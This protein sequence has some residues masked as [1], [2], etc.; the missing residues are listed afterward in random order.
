MTALLVVLKLLLHNACF[1][2]T[3]ASS[4]VDPLLVETSTSKR[5]ETMDT[6]SVQADGD[7]LTLP[8]SLRV[9]ARKTPTPEQQKRIDAVAAKAKKKAT[10]AEPAPVKKKAKA[11]AKRRADGLVEGSAGA[12]LVDAVVKSKSGLTNEELCEMIGWKQCLPFLKKSC[13]QAGVKLTVTKEPG[14]LARYHGTKKKAKA[15]S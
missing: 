5:R 9:E 10:K 8:A 1:V 3:N 15:A 12:K 4:D 13:D 2:L 6:E 7:G 11:E 14:E